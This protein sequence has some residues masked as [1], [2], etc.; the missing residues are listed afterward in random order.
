MFKGLVA[1][2]VAATCITSAPLWA[3]DS[4]GQGGGPPKWTVGVIG[5]A[6]RSPYELENTDADGDVKVNYRAFPYVAYRGDR[7][8]IE[9]MELGYH[10]VKPREDDGLS[11]SLDVVAAARSIAGSSRN[12][13]TADAGLRLGVSSDIGTLQITGLQDV[14]DTHNGTEFSASFSYSFE[15][16]SW[17]F[18]PSIGVT[19]QSEKLAN[20]MWGVTQ[21][22]R[23]KLIEKDKPALPVYTVTSS[24]T[25]YNAGLMWNYRFAGDWSVIAFASGTLLDKTIRANPGIDKKFDATLGLGLAYSF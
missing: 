18:T 13:F 2:S 19:W 8:F 23:D 12:K 17:S 22:Q 25:N 24:A 7:F 15:G 1:A 14:T 21:A 20:H 11:L 16:E 4:D 3:Q 10:L 6:N 5:L 9:G